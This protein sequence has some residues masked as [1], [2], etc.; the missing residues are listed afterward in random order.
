[1]A[2]VIPPTSNVEAAYEDMFKEIT[3]KLYGEETGNGLHTL[4]TPVAQVA[5]TGPTAAPEGEQRSFTNLQI[6]RST[7]PTIEYEHNTSNVVGTTT[8]GSTTSA[9]AASAAAVIAA[10]TSQQNATN[11][12]IQQQPEGSVVVTT[13]T[14]AG[15]NFKSEDHL[16]TAFG[17]A[18]LMQQNGFATTTG[19]ILSSQAINKVITTAAGSQQAQQQQQQQQMSGGDQQQQVWSEGV[20]D[21][22]QQQQSQATPT[23][24]IVQWTTTPS[25][26]LQSYSTTTAQPQT[27]QQQQQQQ[28]QQQV[29]TPKSK[30]KNR[31]DQG[32]S[33][34]TGTAE[35]IYTSPTATGNNISQQQTPQSSANT[36]SSSTTSTSSSGGSS[37]GSSSRKKSHHNQNSQNTNNSNGQSQVQKRYACT[38]CPY[39]TD[40]RDLY[41]RHE[42]IHKDEKPFQ[43]YACLKQF[44]RADHVKKHFL[45]MHREMQYDI[46]KTRRHVPSSNSSGGHH[47]GGGRSNVTI[48]AVNTSPSN[49][50]N[51]GNAIEQKPIIFQTQANVNLEQAFLEQQRQPTSSSLSIAETIEAVATATDVPLPQLKQEKNDDGTLVGGQTASVKPKREKRFTCCYCPW[52]GADKWGLKRHLNTHTK[53][54][55]CLLCDYKAARSERLATHVLKVH[56]KRACNKCSF[57]GDSLE[58]YQQHL[59]EVHLLKMDAISRNTASVAQDFHKAGGVQEL[60]LPAN[61]QLLFNN[62]LPSQWTTKEAAALLQSL[63]NANNL[64]YVY[65][66]QQRSKHA[67]HQ[68]GFMRQR[69]HSNGDDSENTPSTDTSTTS[70]SDDL[71]PLKMEQSRAS[72]EQRKIISSAFLQD[73]LSNSSEHHGLDSSSSSSNNNISHHYHDDQEN[74]EQL[75]RSSPAYKTNNYYMNNNNNNNNINNKNNNN[76]NINKIKSSN[77]SSNSANSNTM[78]NNNIQQQHRVDLHNKENNSNATFL[79][80]ME[81]QNLNKI[82]TQ[83][84][85]YVKDIISKYYAADTPVMFPNMPI[86]TATAQQSQQRLVTHISPKRKRLLSETEEYIEYLKNKEDITLTITPKLADSNSQLQQQSPTPQYTKP[87]LSPLKRERDL[88]SDS[89][90]RHSPKKTIIITSTPQASNQKSCKKSISQLATLLPLL[91]DAASQ[92]QYLTA[93]LDFSKKSSEPTIPHIKQESDA[94]PTGQAFLNIIND[95]PAIKEEPQNPNESQTP[96]IAYADVPPPASATTPPLHCSY[97]D[98][99]SSRKQAQPKKM[100]LSPDLVVAALRDKYLNRMVDRMN[101]LSCADCVKMKRTSMLVFNYH[102]KASLCLHRLW[103]HAEKPIKC[104]MCGDKFRKKFSLILHTMRMHEKAT[105]CSNRKGFDH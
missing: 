65:Q 59:N 91:A 3:R 40:R 67:H 68:N 72:V 43:C 66:Q 73:S 17:L 83:F 54:F 23:T 56:N 12:V 4:G 25:G 97:L 6:D 52:S 21:Q 62:K 1:M 22:Q 89:Y 16:S 101:K 99:R 5:T 86:P 88:A 57:L 45:R 38:H 44:N 60:K 84:Q 41:T 34:S 58:E 29:S 14:S 81:F 75:I 37:G 9:A 48:T 85:N 36:S 90:R 20:Q 70:L 71:S 105:V 80:Q 98:K 82:G 32:S 49:L 95:A 7:Q 42:N 104:K 47:H 96:Q 24:Q 92:Q 39:S 69:Q 13:T 61:H 93:P 35:V 53:P 10:A 77:K 55:V 64:S 63:S 27:Q 46:N 102:T 74:Q 18:A 8:A 50:H 94:K 78:I 15:G 30:N 76:N 2:T 11:V 100:R 51:D 33:P 19:T 28:S 31:N 103:K 26:K 87:P 79:T